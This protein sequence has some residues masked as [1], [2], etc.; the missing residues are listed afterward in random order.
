[1]R[2]RI[3][4][5]LITF[6][7]LT[8]FISKYWKNP[9]PPISQTPLSAELKN[10]KGFSISGTSS[11][12][13]VS[14]RD[15]AVPV[16]FEINS[17][18]Y[19]DPSY[20]KNEYE[21]L[22]RELIETAK[23]RP[24]N[25]EL[26]T[27]TVQSEP[28]RDEGPSAPYEVINFG[29]DKER[30][31]DLIEPESYLY[32]PLESEGITYKNVNLY[33]DLEDEVDVPSLRVKFVRFQFTR[34]RSE[35]ETMIAIGSITFFMG[36]VPIKNVTTVIWN[37]HTGE[38]TPYTGQPWSDSDKWLLVFAFSKPV[39]INRYEITTSIEKPDTDP[40]GWKVE[41]S[42][43]GTYWMLFDDR[44]EVIFPKLR[45]HVVSYYMRDKE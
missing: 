41:G 14:T 22:R 8:Y 18:I 26:K 21:K 24:L 40:N 29:M 4:Y 45:G 38:K 27:P 7:V 3:A 17:N 5:S 23:K 15:L 13:Q 31:V 2:D 11:D 42:Y 10:P 35:N 9:P 36:Q 12:D 19:S 30:N 6:G 16:V 39:S 20:A 25:P 1:M 32:M 28:V 44:T 33:K 37:P 34:P 43:G